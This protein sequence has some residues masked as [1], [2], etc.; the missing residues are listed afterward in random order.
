M[1]KFFKSFRQNLLSE[2]KFS[3]Y[4]AYAIGEIILVVV[5]ILIALWI[6][7]EAEDYK[8]NQ[9]AKQYLHAL[10]SEFEYNK[11]S[12]GKATAR[13]EKNLNLALEILKYTGPDKPVILEKTFD[14]L[15]AHTIGFEVQFKPHNGVIEEIISSGK[16]SLF[17]NP[18]L[19]TSLSSWSGELVGIRYQEEE[20][21]RYRFQLLDLSMQTINIRDV[22][23]AAG[24]SGFDM[25]PSKFKKDN[26]RLLNVQQFESILTTFMGATTY[27]GYRFENLSKKIDTLLIQIDQEL[28]N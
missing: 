7:N 10:K 2:N 18:E 26:L 4:F 12:L 28:K 9:A 19:R 3:K 16:L 23:L 8:N 21:S 5:G 22:S 24:E 1:I 11:Q 6:S 17:K 13:N 14:S 20:L 15:L 27:T 25:L